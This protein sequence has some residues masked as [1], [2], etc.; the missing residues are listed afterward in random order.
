MRSSFSP[1][2]KMF[3]VELK[4]E[5]LEELKG[6]L[7]MNTGGAIQWQQLCHESANLH[8]CASAATIGPMLAAASTQQCCLKP[9][10]CHSCAS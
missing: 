2:K 4:H 8:P 3:R 9:M 7:D 6:C 1:S 5:L 10:L